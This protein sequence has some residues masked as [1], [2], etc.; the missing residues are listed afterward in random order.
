MPYPP[1]RLRGFDHM[2]DSREMLETVVRLVIHPA[3]LELSNEAGQPIEIKVVAYL[4]GEMVE[5]NLLVGESALGA[6][7]RAEVRILLKDINFPFLFSVEAIFYGLSPE[8]GFSGFSLRGKMTLEGE[9][10]QSQLIARSNRYNVW[11]WS[12]GF[13]I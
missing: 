10:P 1:Y 8:T 5:K 2:T 13:R 6:F 12:K 9:A 3:V 7:S 11:N 4:Q